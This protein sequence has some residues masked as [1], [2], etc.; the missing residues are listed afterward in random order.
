MLCSS[1]DLRNNI[2]SLSLYIFLIFF[3]GRNK[4]KNCDEKALEYA[5]KRCPRVLFLNICFNWKKNHSSLMSHEAGLQKGVFSV[6][7]VFLLDT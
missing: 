5:L 1:S 6:I 3:V 4:F 7:C 2:F